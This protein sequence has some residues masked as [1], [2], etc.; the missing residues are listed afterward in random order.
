MKRIA[1]TGGGTGG[2]CAPLRSIALHFTDQYHFVW[3]GENNSM[4][5]QFAWDN[6]IPFFT[7][8][9]AKLRRYFSW[10][11]F[12]IPFELSMGILGAIRILRHERI[13][14]VMSKGGYVSLPVAI[15]ARILRIPIVLHES[16]A[17]PGLANRLVA[18]SAK[19]ILLGMPDARKH[20]AERDVRV[21]GQILDPELWEDMTIP[22]PTGR[23]RTLLVFAGS[24]GASRI[25]DWIL[26]H[27][28]DLADYQITIVLGT[29]NLHYKEKFA[30]YQHIRTYDFVDK[31]T[32]AGIYRGTNIAIARAGATTLAEMRAF[33]ISVMIVPLPESAQDHQRMNARIY[34][35]ESRAL[36]A[37]IV[38]QDELATTGLLSLQSL[39]VRPR[40][41]RII[42]SPT[43]WGEIEGV[44][45]G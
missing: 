3:I 16:D 1:L 40:S 23:Q 45:K 14:L 29:K 9:A 36:D 5:S 38:E 10:R 4:E 22:A 21:V 42:A 2:H 28:F 7:V 41:E 8:R 37:V 15:A 32:L 27:A 26:Q 18:R 11:T 24:Q 6:G 43:D 39:T 12:L 30:V 34:V 44:L 31:K 35:R 20:F 25:Y 17:I 19:T 33:G 13:D